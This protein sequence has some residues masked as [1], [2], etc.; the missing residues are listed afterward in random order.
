ML[1]AFGA[2][3][4]F[5]PSPMRCNS[6]RTSAARRCSQIYDPN[7]YLGLIVALM[8][9]FG[10]TFEFPVILVSLELVGVLT[11]AEAG[12]VAA[13]GHRGHRG[14]RGGH[15]AQRDPFSMLALAVPMYVFYEVS[16]LI[17]RFLRR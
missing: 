4:A 8:L 7:R 11:P 1:F 10:L 2:Y 9:V 13:L 6:C 14:V 3:L 15:H 16:I 12:V 5:V 17:G